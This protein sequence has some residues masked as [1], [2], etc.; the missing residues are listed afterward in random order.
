M[1]HKEMSHGNAEEFHHEKRESKPETK[2]NKVAN[3]VGRNR[4]ARRVRFP[5]NWFIPPAV[6]RIERK[7]KKEK[8]KWKLRE[9]L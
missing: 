8:K 4:P 5:N 7:N 9:C 1:K 3:Q 2:A 6:S